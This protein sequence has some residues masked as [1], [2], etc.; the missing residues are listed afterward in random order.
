MVDW[1]DE[2]DETQPQT[3]AAAGEAQEEATETAAEVPAPK[4]R[5]PKAKKAEPPVPTVEKVEAP[6]AVDDEDD[7]DDEFD[8]SNIALDTAFTDFRSEQDL[9]QLIVRKANRQEWFRVHPTIVVPVLLLVEEEERQVFLL[10]PNLEEFVGDDA[11]P[12]RIYLAVNRQGGYFWLPVTVPNP[13]KA[14]S[15][16][17]SAQAIVLAARTKWVRMVSHIRDGE[18]KALDLQVDLPE[19]KWPDLPLK[20]LLRL[21]FADRYIKSADHPV[22]R[23]LRGLS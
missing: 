16:L 18:Y 23:R 2:D 22:I 10:A 8:V 12:S 11:K 20:R 6:A 14:N 5:K 4:Q 7:Q 17:D 13:T 3:E 19:P 15:W 21:G 9:K 1:F